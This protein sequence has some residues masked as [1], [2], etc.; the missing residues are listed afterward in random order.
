MAGT[1]G[2]PGGGA[3]ASPLRAHTVLRREAGAAGRETRG[4]IAC[5]SSTRSSCRDHDVPE[6]SYDV[7]ESLTPRRRGDPLPRAAIPCCS[8]P[9]ATWA[10][11]RR[12]PTDIESGRPASGCGSRPRRAR[13][14]RR[15]SRVVRASGTGRGR[16]RR[17][18]H[19]LNG[20]EGSPR[21]MIALLE[22]GQ[23]ADGTVTVPPVLRPYLGGRDRLE[24]GAA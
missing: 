22:N 15:T 20:L 21:T 16:A 8:S 3:A 17:L 23:N 1:A 11:L 19:T 14:A 4:L 7:H 24:P 9:R 18:P 10:T 5:I 2:D 13:T 6:T 12:R